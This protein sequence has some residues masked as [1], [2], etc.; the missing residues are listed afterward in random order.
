M[1]VARDPFKALR[2]AE[3][4]GR[5]L[6]YYEQVS[7]GSKLIGQLGVRRCEEPLIRR[8]VRSEGCRVRLRRCG[9]EQRSCAALYYYRFV[10]VL[11]LDLEREESRRRG[12]R[13]PASHVWTTGKLFGYSDYEVGK[14][15]AAKGYINEAPR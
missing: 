15:L 3:T 7:R 6:M 14:F 2:Q 8:T 9:D 10:R 13:P 4:V 1:R 12:R 5:V 11:L